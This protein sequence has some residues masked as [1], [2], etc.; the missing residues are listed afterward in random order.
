MEEVAK[1]WKVASLNVIAWRAIVDSTAKIKRVS[2]NN[3]YCVITVQY[4][5]GIRVPVGVFHQLL[6]GP[7]FN[8]QLSEKGKTIT[9]SIN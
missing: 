8:R 3:Y 9:A 1:A 7:N 2:N 6:I 4:T 5:R